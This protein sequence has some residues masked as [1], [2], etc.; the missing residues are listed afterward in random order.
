MSPS[1]AASMIPNSFKSIKVFLDRFRGAS[2]G[3]WSDD[4]ETSALIRAY[5]RR[6]RRRLMRG[7]TSGRFQRTAKLALRRFARRK[8]TE[9]LNSIKRGRRIALDRDALIARYHRSELLDGLYPPR[10]QRWRIVPRR[11][12]YQTGELSLKDFSFIDYPQKT[13]DALS[14][15]AILECEVVAAKLNFDDPYCSDI[16][17]YLVLSEMWNEM[18]HIFQGGRMSIP[19]QK[20]V[21]AVGLRKPLGMR[22]GGADDLS[23]VWAFPMRRRRPT[24]AAKSPDRYL[25]PQPHEKLADEFCDHIDGWLARAAQDLCLTREGK[26]KVA[27]IIVELLDNAVR[28]SDLI[29]R[30]GSWTVT[31]FMARRKD[32]DSHVFRCHLSFIS[33]GASIAESLA[34]S[35]PRSGGIVR[36]YCERH[37]GGPQ[38]DDTLATLV[39]LQD[40]ITGVPDA[41]KAGRGGVGLQD[42]LEFIN[43]LGATEVAAWAPKLTIVSGSSCIRLREPYLLGKREADDAPRVLWCNA[44]NDAALPPDPAFVFDLEGRLPG[45]VVSM[46]FAIDMDHLKATVREKDPAR[47]ANRRR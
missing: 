33:V 15:I 3:Q 38:S 11:N 46:S 36:E 26:S 2:P 39:A 22:L 41:D 20:V 18:A 34:T 12:R 14:Q 5:V 45:T 30:D 8:A 13:M 1:V 21:E 4:A 47:A 23:D 43:A 42:V 7:A 6:Y 28:H 16:G 37:R 19:I 25:Q 9:L 29:S 27:S 17:P 24:L 44:T 40:G 32:G 10:A 35:G 31:G